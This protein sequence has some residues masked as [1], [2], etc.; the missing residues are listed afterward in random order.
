MPNIDKVFREEVSRLA[1]RAL[2]SEIDSLKRQIQDLK[3]TVR[4]QKKEIDLLKKTSSQSLDLQS[5]SQ[6]V[7]TPEDLEEGKDIRISPDSAKRHRERL[8]LTQRE[9][10]QLLNVSINTVSGW[11]A[12]RSS[13]MGINREMFAGVRTMGVREVQAMLEDNQEEEE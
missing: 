2:R 9:L 1:K 10:A 7:V 13:P 8:R 3:K 5:Q 11:E 12:G 6:V 4:E